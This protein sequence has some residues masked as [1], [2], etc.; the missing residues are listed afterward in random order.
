MQADGLFLAHARDSA[1]HA[2]LVSFPF[3][4]LLSF[5]LCLIDGRL[6]IIPK[7]ILMRLYGET[8]SLLVYTCSPWLEVGIAIPG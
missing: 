8:S 5:F 3:L 2:P 4:S 7:N 6:R 1:F